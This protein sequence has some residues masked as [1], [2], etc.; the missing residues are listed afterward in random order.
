MLEIKLYAGRLYKSLE[1]SSS[2]VSDK[3]MTEK[4]KFKGERCS[5]KSSECFLR[6]HM[7]K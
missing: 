7:F 3:A 4:D 5:C 1:I 6:L 2:Q